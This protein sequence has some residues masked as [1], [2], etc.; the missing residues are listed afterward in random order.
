MVM[1]C[2]RTKEM[3]ASTFSDLMRFGGKIQFIQA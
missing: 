1:V 2:T 3:A